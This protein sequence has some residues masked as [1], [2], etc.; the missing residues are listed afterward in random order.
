MAGIPSVDP[1][2]APLDQL[3]TVDTDNG[4]L[5]K[6]CL[7]VALFFYRLPARRK[8]PGGTGYSCR[9]PRS[10]GRPAN[11]DNQPHRRPLEKA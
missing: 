4:V 11:L 6:V 3:L 7:G 10:G 9:L 1:L 8:T 5:F 2:P